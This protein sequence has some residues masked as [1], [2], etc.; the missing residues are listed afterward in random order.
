MFVHERTVF[1]KLIQKLQE[2]SI[3]SQNQLVICFL[4]FL[5]KINVNGGDIF[6]A[7]EDSSRDEWKASFNFI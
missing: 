4:F 1:Q 3:L 2:A 7:P 6:H 5:V